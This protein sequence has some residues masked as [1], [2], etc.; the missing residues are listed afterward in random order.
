MYHVITQKIVIRFL[1][2]RKKVCTIERLPDGKVANGNW[3]PNP[4]FRKVKFNWNGPDNSNSNNGARLEVSRKKPESRLLLRHV[5]DPAIEHLGYFNEL[6]G[7]S[8]VCSLVD[9]IQFMLGS[10][11]MFECF[12]PYSRSLK[13]FQLRLLSAEC[14]FDQ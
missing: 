12:T 4:N 14:R 8:E 5:A 10:D 2:T 6:F 7:D 1:V 13:D 9:D 11:E 3:N